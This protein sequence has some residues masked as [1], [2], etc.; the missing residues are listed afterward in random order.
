MLYSSIKSQILSRV[1]MFERYRKFVAPIKIKDD[2]EQTRVFAL[3]KRMLLIFIG[4]K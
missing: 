2:L 4:L 3:L 1:D